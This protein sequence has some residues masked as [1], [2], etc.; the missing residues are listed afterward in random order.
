MNSLLIVDD[1]IFTVDII[2]SQFCWEELGIDEVYT[3]YSMNQAVKVLEQYPVD[4]MICDIEMGTHSGLELLE[5][6]RKHHLPVVSFFLT[7]HAQ[8]DYCR[9]AIELG[10]I[11]YVLKP[12]EFDK[13]REIIL[14][15]VARAEEQKAKAKYR[16]QSENWLQSSKN[17]LTQFWSDIISETIAPDRE[18]ILHK[19]GL[20]GISMEPE[21]RYL[22]LLSHWNQPE[23]AAERWGK[24]DLRY[25]LNNM[26]TD[27]LEGLVT[28][29]S[30]ITT[31]S[32]YYIIRQLEKDPERQLQKLMEDC[33]RMDGYARK[34]L[35]AELS[36]CLGSFQPPEKMSRQFRQVLDFFQSRGKPGAE[37]LLLERDAEQK[38]PYRKPDIQTWMMLLEKGRGR[39]LQSAVE[40]YLDQCLE[41][42]LLNGFTL[43]QFQRDFY[44]MIYTVADRFFIDRTEI[45]GE[46]QWSFSDLEGVKRSAGNIIQWLTRRLSEGTGGGNAMDRAKSYIDAN[47][48]GADISRDAVAE[49]VGLNPEYL[50]RSFKKQEG[51]SLLEYIQSKKVEIACG[52]LKDTGLSVSEVAARL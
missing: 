31:R 10:S 44:Y 11:D 14:T 18:I 24:T 50:S 16:Q 9:R 35:E 1:E 19:A 5:W 6:V 21:S 48:L 52:L 28:A 2:K 45:G 34:H 22:L 33:R 25:A 29:T 49:H 43:Q 13:L 32:N 51:I 12:I 30:A 38:T 36:F 42:G 4:V 15:A 39:D 8:F 27:L 37:I 47:I 20:R 3:A 41:R 40:R 17:L 7:G 46:V 26:A 23:D